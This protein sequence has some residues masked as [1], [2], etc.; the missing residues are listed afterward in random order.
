MSRLG[1][2]AGCYWQQTIGRGVGLVSRHSYLE[3]LV[4][5]ELAEL[6]KQILLTL[7]ENCWND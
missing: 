5:G 2:L 3:R 7:T 6:T 1:Q 4:I